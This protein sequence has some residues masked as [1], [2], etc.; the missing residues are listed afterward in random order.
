[1]VPRG[2][3]QGCAFVPGDRND[4]GRKRIAALLV[5]SHS[6]PGARSE[7]FEVIR[8]LSMGTR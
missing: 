7:A 5:S 8:L 6:E 3:E 4:Q 2:V 1:M